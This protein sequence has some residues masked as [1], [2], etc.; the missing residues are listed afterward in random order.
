MPREEKGRSIWG[1]PQPSMLSLLSNPRDFSSQH[2]QSLACCLQISLHTHHPAEGSCKVPMC[3]TTSSFHCLSPAPNSLTEWPEILLWEDTQYPFP[4][5]FPGRQKGRNEPHGKLRAGFAQK[6]IWGGCHPTVIHLT[7][8][9]G[10]EGGTVL[11]S[12]SAQLCL[13]L[14]PVCHQRGC[15]APLFFPHSIPL[16][17][18]RTQANVPPDKR[19]PSTF[20]LPS[21]E[22]PA[23]PSSRHRWDKSWGGMEQTDSQAQGELQ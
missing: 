14:Q 12:P 10:T 5:C 3:V 4:R 6:G 1:F 7:W 22:V 13:L 2:Q 20:S 18:P 23:Q 11:L 17:F 19:T 8:P 9:E 15:R 21:W 16:C